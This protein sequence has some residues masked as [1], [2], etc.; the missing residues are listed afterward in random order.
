MSDPS[1]PLG[2]TVHSLPQPGVALTRQRDSGRFKMLMVLL[3]CAAPVLASYYTYY[4]ARPSGGTAYSTLIQPAVAMPAVVARTLSGQPQP[5]RDLVGQWQ[6]V[7]VSGGAC[8]AVCERRLFLQRQL[9]EM[10]G[11]E[12][13]RVEKLWLLVDDA[14][15]P[16]ALRAAIEATPAMNMDIYPT[17]VDL[18][19]LPPSTG[20]EGSSLVPVLQGADDGRNRIALSE[21]YRGSYAGRMIR[22][23]QWK[24]FFYTNGEEYLYNLTADP[25]E[26]TN[27][28]TK[29]E[30]RK[31]AD[32]LKQRATAGWIQAKPG[33]SDGSSAAQAAR[34]AARKAKK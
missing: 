11:R 4:V 30:N 32:E 18:C 13:D 8:D 34:K 24:Y 28:I 14:P 5:L 2:L 19:H 21:N 25:W 17:L 23:A 26:E 6:L 9:R 1:E 10:V 16:A 7:V 31:L 33:V 3:V 12:A 29:P 22:T 20:L 27:L 15:V